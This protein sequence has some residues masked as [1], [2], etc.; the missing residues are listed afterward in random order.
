METVEILLATH[1]GE[2]YLREQLD[3]ILNQNY[4]NWIVR[5]YDDASSDNT[6]EILLE[7]Q[8]RFPE[9]FIVRK[10]EERL[11]SAK[12][13]F[14]KLIRESTCSYVMCCDQDDVWL[15]DKISLTLNEMKRME[16]LHEDIPI[17][18]HTDLK[19]V[20]EQL[21]VKSH[22]F[23]QYSKLNKN[24][25]YQDV[26]IQNFVTGCTI[27]MNRTLADLLGREI[28]IDHILMHDW[29]AAIVASGTGVVGFVDCP[30]MLYRQH[31]VNS[32]G[33]KEYGFFL[34]VQKIKNKTMR[35]TLIQTTIQ[36]SQ[37]AS[38]YKEELGQ[39]YYALTSE[40]G[41]L[42]TKNKITRLYFYLKYK[43]LKHGFF[44][45]VWQLI[46]G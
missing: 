8:Q 37:I 32:V 18:V 17:L 38:I 7:Y 39:T 5:A 44:R 45:K 2:R 15:E 19:V 41:Q 42:F 23:V 11:G 4:S 31:S 43:V 22:S 14:M 34:F 16:K 35:K 20:D 40:Y 6:Y 28:N 25:A 46:L 1:N 9:R 10:N 3:S 12:K 21:H 30:T 36:A 24:F 13:N 33:A 26:L 29:L 27:M